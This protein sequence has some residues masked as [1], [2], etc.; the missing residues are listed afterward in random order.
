MLKYPGWND[1]TADLN[2]KYTGDLKGNKIGV[3]EWVKTATESI[4]RKLLA[5]K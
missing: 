3:S 2:T 4:D 1:V 5:K